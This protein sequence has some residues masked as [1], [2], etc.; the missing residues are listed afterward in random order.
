MGISINDLATK[1]KALLS[2]SKYDFS[3][4]RWQGK[5]IVTPHKNN[6]KYLAESIL[7]MNERVSYVS[8]LMSG[9]SGSGKSSAI[10]TLIHR[11]SCMQKEKRIVKWFSGKDLHNL[12]EII[13]KLK[14]NNAQKYCL[15][16]D[17][18]SYQ[19]ELTGSAIKK[20]QIASKLTTIR[21]DIG[22]GSKVIVFFSIHFLT[23]LIPI[24][25]DS[26]FRI[27]TSMSDQDRSNWENVFGKT[28]RYPLSKF[29][30]QYGSQMQRGY[31][32]LNNN[33]D[34]KQNNYFHVDQP[35]RITL[36]SEISGLRNVLIPKE[37][38]NFCR[39]PKSKKIKEKISAQEF[40]NDITKAYGKRAKNALGFFMY[41][42]KGNTGILP[43]QNIRA[44]NHITKKLEKY[45]IDLD[46]LSEIASNNV[47]GTRKN[48][49][50]KK[51]IEYHKKQELLKIPKITPENMTIFD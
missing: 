41:F 14:K 36:V 47:V 19:M 40:F 27:L 6:I 5:D 24:M 50:M 16:F 22:E 3:R 49:H 43:V 20:K 29:Q 11:M 9:Q 18:I 44:L 37:E 15:V 32:Y 7:Q 26:S 23:A 46:E 4:Y 39:E 30:K 13:D 48:I 33:T 1:R 34:E 42:R 25:R 10:T 45:D 8:V 28:S 17:D 35:Y 51:D 38:C 21:H 12:D 2:K 31:F